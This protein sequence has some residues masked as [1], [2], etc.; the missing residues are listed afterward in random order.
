MND[1]EVAKEI[2][3]LQKIIDSKELTDALTKRLLI[4]GELVIK[5][6]TEIKTD[7]INHTMDITADLHEMRMDSIENMRDAK[8]EFINVK[9]AIANFHHDIRI[10]SRWLMAISIAIL[11]FLILIFFK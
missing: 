6:S 4:L 8:L 10:K 11:I 3:E 1:K 9:H 2:Q 5:Q 7:V